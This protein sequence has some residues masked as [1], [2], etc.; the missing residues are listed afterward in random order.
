T[1]AEFCAMQNHVIFAGDLA[2]LGFT[3][4]QVAGLVRSGQLRRVFRGAFTIDTGTEFHEPYRRAVE[5]Y[6]RTSGHAVRPLAG[7]AALVHCGLPIWG[8]AP[9]GLHVIGG[10]QGTRSIIRPLDPVR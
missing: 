6:V 5:A 9:D 3:P 2:S 1:I 8:R 10:K 4:R 7:P